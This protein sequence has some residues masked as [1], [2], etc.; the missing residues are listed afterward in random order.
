MNT[1]QVPDTLVRKQMWKLVSAVSGMVGALVAKTVIKRAYQAIRKEEP[2]SAFDPTAARF[3]WPNALAWAA[4][5]GI[6]LITAR[7]VSA[8][9]AAIGWKAATGTLPPGAVEQSPAG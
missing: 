1:R 5:G 2:T 9:L 7:I 3:S 4:A 6:G 8:R